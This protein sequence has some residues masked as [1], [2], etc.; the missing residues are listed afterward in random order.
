MTAL[1]NKIVTRGF[2]PI[3]TVPNN[4]GPITMG[5]GPVPP[6]F[7]VSAFQSAI[8]HGGQ[9][10]FKRRMQEL[11]EVIVWAKLIQ[12]NNNSSPPN[13]KGFV[14]IPVPR[15]QAKTSVTVEHV[16]SLIRSSPEIINVDDESIEEQSN[17]RG[18][19]SVKVD[20]NRGYVSIVAEHIASGTK[21]AW[22]LIKVTA[23]RLK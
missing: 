13:I 4:S 3:R 12:I 20:K 1:A 11:D 22:N 6:A 19:I 16:A 10:G 5:Y 18:S 14:R 2:G 17:I 23:S 15:T 7:V 21:N 9:S 8:R